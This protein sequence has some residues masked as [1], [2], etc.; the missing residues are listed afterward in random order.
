MPEKLDARAKRSQSALLRSGL[1]L[2]NN[3]PDA[4]LSEIA[5]HAGV[6]RTTVYRQYQSREKLILA[7]AL[8]CLKTMEEATS[9]IAKQALSVLD[10]IRLLF[11]TMMPLT[12]E[13]QFLMNSDKL[14]KGS[15]SIAEINLKHKQELRDLVNY[16][17]QLGE[18]DKSLPTSWLVN[19]I[20]G[21]LFVG[22]VQQQKDGGSAEEA[23]ALAFR[24]FTQGVSA[25]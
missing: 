24:S 8:Y 12:A 20:E 23:A 4:S 15:P 14:I 25:R 17:K 2:L 19:L 5:Q 10:A 3:N 16:G 18:I 9:P 22:W 6:G 7:I 1:E 21:L 11:E 13:F